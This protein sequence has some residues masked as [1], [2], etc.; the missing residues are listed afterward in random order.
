MKI[1]SQSSSAHK[2]DPTQTKLRF[3]TNDSNLIKD[4]LGRAHKGLEI[5]VFYGWH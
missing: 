1:T 5:S 3:I 2:E 4:V